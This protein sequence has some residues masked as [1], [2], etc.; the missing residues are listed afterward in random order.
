MSDSLILSFLVSNVRES[1]RSLTKN[2]QCEQIAQV[3]NQKWA[4]MSDSLRALRGNEQSWAN[5]LGSSPKMSEWVNRSFFWVNH[6]FLGK[7]SDLLGIPMS[8]FPALQQPHT[9]KQFKNHSNLTA[10]QKNVKFDPPFPLRTPKF[11]QLGPRLAL[12]WVTIQRLVVDAV[13]SNTVKSQKRR[14]GAPS[15]LQTAEVH[16]FT[17]RWQTV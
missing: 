16:G 17:L 10:D 8:E 3:A 1:L 7:T 14:I 4:T 15:R 9:I 2:E 11:K 6:W 5:C 13:V 12:G